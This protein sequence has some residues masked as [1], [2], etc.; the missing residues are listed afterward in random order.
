M[1]CQFTTNLNALRT[2]DDPEVVHQARVGWRRFR[3]ARRLFK[4]VLAVDA[5]PSW[6]SLHSLLVFMGELR[7]LDVARTETL[8]PLADAYTEG[9]ARREEKWRAMAQALTH[10]AM[11]QRKSIRYALEAPAIGSA[12][13]ATT[14]WLEELSAPK[15]S[16]DARVDLKTSL[17]RWARRRIV[18]LHD[19][20]KVALRDSA[21]P[22]GQ[23][24]VRIL[25][26]RM[27]YGI[28]ALRPLLPKRHTKRWYPQATNL[29]TSIG[30]I[31]DVMQAG[32]LAAK[33]E[34]DPGL[35]EFLRG[36]AVGQERPR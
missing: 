28:E 4:P 18:R 10:A 35:V 34:V 27:R 29:Q 25:S 2:S 30:A 33:T 31:R 11:L 8:P 13:L 14:Q 3:S 32:V 16:G 24:R 36:V 22:D 23:H 1:F 12:L 5:V 15:G 19:Q 7:D 17:R 20:L 9:D 26:K 6:Q 21:N